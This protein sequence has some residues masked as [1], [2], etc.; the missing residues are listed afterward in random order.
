MYLTGIYAEKC[1]NYPFINLLVLCDKFGKEGPTEFKKDRYF[2]MFQS[3]N[4]N[5]NRSEGAFSLKFFGD[6]TKVCE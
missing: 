2:F 5:Q 3:R 4:G 6:T 1:D